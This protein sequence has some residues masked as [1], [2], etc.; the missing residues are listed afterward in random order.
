MPRLT[1]DPTTPF[2]RAAALRA[3]VTDAMLRG[4]GFRRLYTGAHISSDVRVW[5]TTYIEA[6]LLL[7]PPSAFASHFSA[8]VIHRLPVPDD[9]E[10]H[11]SVFTKADRRRRDGIRHHTAVAEAAVT[12]HLG[13]RVSSPV[14][15][16]LELADTLSLVD[17]VVLGDAIVKRGLATTGDLRQASRAWTARGSE[18]AR[19]AADLLREGVDSPM[20]SRLRMLI[21]LAGLPEPFVNFTLRRRDGSVMM[22]LDL[23]YPDLRIVIEY[24]GQQH[25]TNLDQWDTDIQ[26]DE[27]FGE[28][29]WRVVKVVARD[30]YRRPDRTIERVHRA[31]ESRHARN[32]PRTLS[33]EWRRYFPV[34]P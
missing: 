4:P 22:R 23:S 3:G 33:D 27:W 18:L 20:E 5:P 29:E 10:V 7:H 31:L 14:Q 11:I 13:V 9:H 6:A 15:L 1:F 19:R 17:L 8:A 16:F 32:L 30:I 2:T 21:V 34:R 12:T 25:R 28:E 26:R 24:D